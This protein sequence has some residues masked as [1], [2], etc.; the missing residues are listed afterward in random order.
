[1]T[2]LD[3]VG[4]CPAC[5]KPLFL[6][7][8]IYNKDFSFRGKSSWHQRPYKFFAVNCDIPY[9]EFFYTV[10]ESQASRG[11]R[12]IIR[13]DIT[14]IYP[15]CDKKWRNLT[16]A[17]MLHFLEHMSLVSHGP[18]CTNKDYLIRKITKNKCGNQFL[19]QQKYVEFLSI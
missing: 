11:I 8:T 18:N 7:D 1:M 13:F 5:A 14:R 12:P 2:D 10:D 3:V 6:A 4:I 9:Y 19:R 16:P 15:N 17:D